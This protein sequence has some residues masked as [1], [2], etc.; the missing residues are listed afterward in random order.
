MSETIDLLNRLGNHWA[1][2]AWA[3]LWQSSLL[4][5]GLWL[6]DLVLRR[7]VRPIVRHALWLLVPLKLLLPPSLALPTSPAYWIP[8]PGPAEA[9]ARFSAW[10]VE[11]GMDHGPGR[12]SLSPPSNGADRAR[13]PTPPLTGP[14]VGMMI[15]VAGMLALLGVLARR[16]RFLR[17]SRSEPE[18]PSELVGPSMTALRE[19][20]RLKRS[21]ELRWIDEGQSPAL[22]GWWRQR[23]LMPRNLAENLTPAQLRGVLMHELVHARRGDVWV[24]ALQVVVQIL[25][26]WHPL[27]W[28][29]NARL[30]AVREEAVDDEVAFRL[31]A[32]SETYP[33]A[34]LAVAKAAVFRSRLSLGFLG[35]V[36]SRS[37]LRTRIERLLSDPP[38]ALPCLGLRG[39]LAV[40][41]IGLLLIPMAGS[42]AGAKETVG[43][44][45]P[46]TGQVTAV[47]ITHMRGPEEQVAR[48]GEAIYELGRQSPFIQIQ[49]E[50]SFVEITPQAFRTIFPDPDAD[51]RP[52][53]AEPHPTRLLSA[54]ARR[55]LDFRLGAQDGVRRIGAP[56]VTTLNGRA[57]EIRQTSSPAE[58]GETVS[59]R[60][61]P[62]IVDD[63]RSIWLDTVTTWTRV[64]DSRQLERSLATGRGEGTPAKEPEGGGTVHALQAVGY[65][66]HRLTNAVVLRDGETCLVM[67]P[68]S[69]ELANGQSLRTFPLVLIGATLIDPAG[70]PVH[71]PVP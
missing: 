11:N 15:W 17:V 43:P 23:L 38:S 64:L 68:G 26:W 29:A 12:S 5:A 4:I 7:R 16:S 10:L 22:F 3:G 39:V 9:T 61:L 42:R 69:L 48:V 36:E 19:S 50:A 24:N 63:G 32:E 40:G 51:R 27:V 47:E 45:P 2:V 31:G 71:P 13:G 46:S 70:N 56:R 20:L 54:E 34:L 33:E 8:R 52:D 62:E 67:N 14:A 35:I 25:W 28:L 57:A 49:I 65:I 21:V 59:L 58:G 60:V 30:R 37:Q 41:A 18:S 1:D 55:R 6:A 53:T 44:A 66:D